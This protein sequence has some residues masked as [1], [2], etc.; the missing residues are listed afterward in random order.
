MA[1]VFIKGS[2]SSDIVTEI[3]RKIEQIIIDSL[4]KKY[5]SHKFVCQRAQYIV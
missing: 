2:N 5:P 3:D 4:K 1:S